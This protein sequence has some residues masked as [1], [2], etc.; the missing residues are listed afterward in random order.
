MDAPATY[1]QLGFIVIS[2]PNL[3]VI[4]GMVALF[5]AALLAPFPAHQPIEQ[6]GDE[7]PE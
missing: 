3:L 5:I 6:D 4:V 2:V 7:P 1:V